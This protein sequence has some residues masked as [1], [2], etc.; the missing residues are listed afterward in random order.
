MFEELFDL[1]KSSPDTQGMEKKV[2]VKK[3]KAHPQKGAKR[4]SSQEDNPSFEKSFHELQT[5][6]EEME[7][8]DIPLEK[9]LEKFERGIALIKECTELLRSAR[10]RVEK[11]IEERDGTYRI[12]GLGNNLD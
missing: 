12:K 5:I 2:N 7:R 10:L 3:V 4:E 1:E 9:L 11:Y 8:E 6:V